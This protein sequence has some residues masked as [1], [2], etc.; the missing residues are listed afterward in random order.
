MV[1]TDC[2][3]GNDTAGPTVPSQA[4]IPT[5]SAAAATTDATGYVVWHRKHLRVAD[6]RALA[7]AVAG[8]D[9]VCPLF[10]FDPRFYG[11]AGLACDS[12][13]RFLHEAV[14]SL[15][16]QYMNTPTDSTETTASESWRLLVDEMCPEQP[17][18]RQS[19]R[20]SDPPDVLRPPEVGGLTIG[21]GDPV[22]LLSRFIDR[23]WSVVTMAAP[24]GRYGYQRDERIKRVCGNAVEF[25]S[26]DGLV[27]GEEWP[28][29]RWQERVESWLETPRHEPEWR[30]HETT[31]V[32]IDTGLTPAAI[33]DVFAV[34]PTKTKVPSGT[35]REAIIRLREFIERIRSYPG[36]ISAPQ[37]ARGGTSGLSPYLNFG[38][39]SVRQVYQHCTESAPES[40]GRSMFLSRLF[41]NR[42]YNQK[43]ADWPGWT[44][45]AVNPVFAGFNDE[46]H[47][48]ALVT[49][50]KRG[51]TGYPMVDASMRCLRDT[52]W[53]NFRMRAMCA[54]FFSHILQQPWRI[55]ADWYHH[56][57]IDSDVG[58]NYTQWQSQAGLIGKPSQRVYNPRKQVRDNDP[59]GEWITEWVPELTDLPEAFLPRPERTPLAVQEECGVRIGDVYPLPVVEFEARREAFWDRYERLRPAAAELL[60]RPDIAKRASF[61]GGYSA[62]RAIAEK[63]GSGSVSGDTTRQTSLGDID[64]NRRGHQGPLGDPDDTVETPRPAG[65]DGRSTCVGAIP[66]GVGQ[67]AGDPSP[68]DRAATPAEPEE[69]TA[70]REQSDAEATETDDCGV[71]N[72]DG[73]ATLDRFS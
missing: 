15:E 53:L 61:S 52:G 24:T 9:A 33:D 66:T 57:L 54:S 26:G 60:R 67:Q 51:Q 59:G 65:P 31:R 20:Q 39:L 73:Q 36:N 68:D 17:S 5:P 21:Y 38:L 12:R 43:L 64:K 44:T 70:S 18:S 11:D 55:G 48:P 19:M 42:H 2:T 40:G 63:H 22:V 72:G 41:W 49:A 7:E 1:D 50:W 32:T 35:H 23:G 71:G 13:L 25:V 27:R 62:A 30:Q 34:T 14:T 16:R 37:D 8:G 3:E 6:H 47:D 45:E 56:H 58:I 46:T 29:D 4:E 28:R 69:T 10:V